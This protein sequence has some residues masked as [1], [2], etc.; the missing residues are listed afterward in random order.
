MEREPVT[1]W[2]WFLAAVCALAAGAIALGGLDHPVFLA[3]NRGAAALP[4]GVASCLTTIGDGFVAIM[5][6]APTMRRNPQVLAA[7]LYATPLAGAFS[8]VGK[9]IASVP[10]PAAVLDPGSIHI[11][12]P[13]LAGHNSFP[14]GHSITIFLLASVLLLGWPA[15][16][17]RAVVCGLLLLFALVAGFSRVMV[18]AHWPSDVMGGAALGIV[19]GI[20]GS[21]AASAWPLWRKRYASVVIALVVLGCAAYLAFSQIDYPLAQPLQWV[22]AALGAGCSILTL[23]RPGASRT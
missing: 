2:C 22:A 16:R 18:G 19:A 10:R 1:R 12:G 14:S 9:R 23:V 11:E 7:A 15:L 17:G 6:L 13:T 20:F 21:W 8:W 3:V 4:A 5:L